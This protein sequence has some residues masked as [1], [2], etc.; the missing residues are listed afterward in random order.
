MR[1][2]SFPSSPFPYHPLTFLYSLSP[3]SHSTSG[4]VKLIWTPSPHRMSPCPSPVFPP[5]FSLY[6]VHPAQVRFHLLPSLSHSSVLILI[7][8][9]LSYPI[10]PD[11]DIQSE[12]VDL[13]GYDFDLLSLL[14]KHRSELL[15]NLSE[16][17]S[18]TENHGDRAYPVR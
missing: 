8:P 16:K 15:K 10:L 18:Y 13:L 2:N 7:Y 17:V 1:L 4:N 14:L 11:D 12:L 6:F 5:I 3:C 9:I